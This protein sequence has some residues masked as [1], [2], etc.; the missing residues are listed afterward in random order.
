MGYKKRNGKVVD[1]VATPDDLSP[2]VKGSA[3]DLVEN[4]PIESVDPK[5]TDHVEQNSN[6]FT[7]A[8]RSKWPRRGHTPGSVFGGDGKVVTNPGLRQTGWSPDDE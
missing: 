8:D 7:A 3:P 4:V 1:H 2:N 6:Y 5:K